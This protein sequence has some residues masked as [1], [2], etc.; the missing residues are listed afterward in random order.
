MK[1]LGEGAQRAAHVG[2]MA[3][4]VADGTHAIEA[5]AVA[6]QDAELRAVGLPRRIVREVPQGLQRQARVAV[7][8]LG[9]AHAGQLSNLGS[10]A[11]PSSCITRGIAATGPT[12]MVPPAAGR[13]DAEAQKYQ[14]WSW[15]KGSVLPLRGRIALQSGRK[16]QEDRAVR[17]IDF[18]DCLR[19]LGPFLAARGSS[20]PPD[21]T[22]RLTCDSV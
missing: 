15:S 10:T 20:C 21:L 9:Q 3:Q 16:M 7:D 19:S 14:G 22:R 2:R 6:H 8:E 11:T 1:F 17:P 13:G 18:S 4:Q 12:R 5:E